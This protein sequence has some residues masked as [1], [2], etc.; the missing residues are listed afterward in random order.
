MK[1]NQNQYSG[2][3]NDKKGR[4][5]P[6]S[7]YVAT[8]TRKIYV[9][10]DAGIPRLA[11]ATGGGGAGVVIVDFYTGLPTGSVEDSVAFVLNSQGAQWLPG[12]LG[13]TYYPEGWYILRSGIWVHSR[14]PV[15]NQIGLNTTLI[16]SNKN[17][18]DSHILQQN[19]PHLVTKTQVGLGNVD[20]TSDLSKP[21]STST[22][23]ALD[24]KSST[25]HTHVKANITDFIEGDYATAAQGAKA[26]TALQTGD[27]ISKLVNDQ[28][29]LQPG[30]NISVFVN[31]AAYLTSKTLTSFRSDWETADIIYSG[32]LLD[33]V[34]T[35]KKCDNGIETFGQSLT[36]LETDWSNRLSLTYI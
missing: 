23:T 32:Y 25:V 22:Q 15:D 21:I 17:S 16:S 30:E 34:I 27:N 33:S 24:G 7:V 9:Y 28:V 29:Y 1:L 18:I 19:N 31:D 12:N 36:N 20:N 3:D 6:G 14:Y 13:G 5:T 2:R 11:S 8:D 35:I 10:D 26:D 4:L